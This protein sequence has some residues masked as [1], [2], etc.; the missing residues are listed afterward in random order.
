MKYDK[1]FTE[2]FSEMF[3]SISRHKNTEQ[4][5]AYVDGA[6]DFCNKM[7]EMGFVVFECMEFHRIVRA[8]I[9]LWLLTVLLVWKLAAQQ[10]AKEIEIHTEQGYFTV[11]ENAGRDSLY[12]RFTPTAHLCPEAETDSGFMAV[13][14]SKFTTPWMP[15]AEK[16]GTVLWL[17][18]SAQ[19]GYKTFVSYVGV[20]PSDL[21]QRQ[22][23]TGRN[24]HLMLLRNFPSVSVQR[25]YDTVFTEKTEKN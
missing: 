13:R 19:Y 25:A 21:A 5:S 11:S 10:P 6:R 9:L 22:F 16:A 8:L 4:K 17:A 20:K 15:T 12:F 3:D 24:L 2:V 14:V 23:M 7:Q 1:I 18:R